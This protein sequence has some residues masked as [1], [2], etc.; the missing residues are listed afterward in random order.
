MRRFAWLLPLVLMTACEGPVG[1]MGP[2]GPKGEQGEP[3]P[4]TRLVFTAT[5]NS[6]GEAFAALPA[7]AG[8]LSDPPAVTCYVA[9]QGSSVFLLV[10]V[11]TYSGITCG[12]GTQGGVLYAIMVDAPAFWIARFVV[13][14]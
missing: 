12:I 6:N 4:G 11:D 2:A 5:V 7:A 3:G 10:S 13:V 1:P 14:Y 8:S 9:Q